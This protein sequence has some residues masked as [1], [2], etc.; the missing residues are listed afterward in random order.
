MEVLLTRNTIFPE[1][2]GVSK[3]VAENSVQ[4]H[5]RPGSNLKLVKENRLSKICQ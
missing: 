3:T 2:S 4:P 5:S 1:K